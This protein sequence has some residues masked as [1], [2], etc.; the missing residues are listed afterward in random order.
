[1]EI[2]TTLMKIKMAE[3]TTIKNPILVFLQIHVT[4]ITQTQFIVLSI[5]SNS[6]ASWLGGQNF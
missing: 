1:M 6:S 3:S 2:I 5:A 4:I